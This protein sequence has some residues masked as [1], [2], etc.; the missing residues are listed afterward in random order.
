MAAPTL[1]IGDNVILRD[2]LDETPVPIGFGSPIALGS[3]NAVT[4]GPPATADVIFSTE[5]GGAQETVNE[6]DTAL[7]GR[8]DTASAAIGP[9]G[10]LVS[11][12]ANELERYT[13]GMRVVLA[14]D[15]VIVQGTPIPG[16][17]VRSTFAPQSPFYP[18]RLFF[19]RNTSMQLEPE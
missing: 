15:L 7:L 1:V 18:N 11:L 10:T 19:V 12:T 4:A 14:C 5:G 3:V 9:P 17:I 13:V 16:A 2:L 8:L 6:I